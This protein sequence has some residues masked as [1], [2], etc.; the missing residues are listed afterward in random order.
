SAG[1]P[2]ATAGRT[3]C[4]PYFVLDGVGTGAAVAVVVLVGD[5]TGAGVALDVGTGS[6]P[7]VRV[8][9]GTGR[10]AVPAGTVG[11]VVLGDGTA[12]CDGCGDTVV[13]AGAGAAVSPG[14]EPCV[15]LGDGCKPAGLVDAGTGRGAPSAEADIA[16]IAVPAIV[17]AT[18]AEVSRT[19]RIRC[20]RETPDE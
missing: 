11:A 15:M 12:V 20:I 18:T 19:A 1:P 8:G 17:A 14:C 16:A 13:G 7:A 6:G 2:R 5:G 4:A 10:G 3:S 9:D